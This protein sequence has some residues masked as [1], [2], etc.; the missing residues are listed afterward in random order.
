MTAAKVILKHCPDYGGANVARAVQSQF[1]LLGG[2]KR[3]VK[4]GDSVLLKPNFIAPRSPE[5]APAQTHPTVI[6]EVARLLKDYGAKPFVADSSAWADAA[7]CAN[8]LGLTEP[9]SELGVPVKELDRPVKRRLGPGLP[10][11]RISSVALEADVIINLPKFKAHQQLLTTFAIKNM[12]GCV[13]GKRKAMWHFRRGADPAEFC[14]LLIG[15]C[16]HLAPALTI[17]DGIVAMEGRGPIGGRHKPLGWL[18]AGT[19]AVACETVCCGLVDLKPEAVPILQTARS[20]GFG[21]SDPDQIEILGD[22]LPA[23][24]CRDFVLPELGP[25]RFSLPHVCRSVARQ[26]LLR[27]RGGRARTQPTNY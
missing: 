7:T 16:R 3:F 4:P 17:I 5:R 18:I 10:S 1:E 27:L 25:I 21:C 6:V 11:V 19:D 13:T 15:I 2:L 8:V 12:F 9:L 24:P 20:V 22:A 14:R 23:E 26:I